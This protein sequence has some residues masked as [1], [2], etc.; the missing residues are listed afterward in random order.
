MGFFYL[1][2]LSN[3]QAFVCFY[4]FYNFTVIRIYYFHVNMACLFFCGLFSRFEFVTYYNLY[5]RIYL[6]KDI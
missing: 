1:V 6:Y 2:Y 4:A 5:N 3:L